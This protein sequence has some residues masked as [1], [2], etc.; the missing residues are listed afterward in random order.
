MFKFILGVGVYF[1]AILLM[2]Y[3]FVGVSLI[4]ATQMAS[5]ITILHLLIRLIDKLYKREKNN[6]EEY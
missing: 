2:S 5:L 1:F 3:Y 6:R 4:K